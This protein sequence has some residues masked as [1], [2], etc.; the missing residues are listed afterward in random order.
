M[1]IVVGTRNKVKLTACEKA[2]NKIKSKYPSQFK[3]AISID[4]FSAKS[5]VSDMPLSL[6][7]LLNG[8]R[9]RALDVYNSLALK[10]NFTIGME[11]GVFHTTDFNSNPTNDI[12]QSWVYVFNG[13]I[14]YYGCSA[15]IPVPQNISDEIGRAS[16]RER[17]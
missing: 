12:L 1:K 6:N 9:N 15:G 5:G 16:C 10:P 8:A 4:G 17:V 2:F 3:K 11:G 7:E 13:K 14:G